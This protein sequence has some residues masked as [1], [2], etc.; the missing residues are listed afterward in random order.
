MTSR[1][2]C[3]CVCVSETPR[4]LVQTPE[5]CSRSETEEEEEEETKLLLLQPIRRE[6]VR[7]PD[8]HLPPDWPKYETILPPTTF[9]VRSET[10]VLSWSAAKVSELTVYCRADQPI[11]AVARR[12][13]IQMCCR[14]KEIFCRFQ[15]WV[16]FR[17]FFLERNQQNL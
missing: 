3:V 11:T 14:F 17:L 12:V 5:T 10:V 1:G 16:F 15:F 9:K 7:P 13:S 2:V 4:E 6:T 8:R